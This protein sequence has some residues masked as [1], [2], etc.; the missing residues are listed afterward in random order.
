MRVKCAER[1]GE[2]DVKAV[3][4]GR[5]DSRRGVVFCRSTVGV[6]EFVWSPDVTLK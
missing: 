1:G 6:N 2:G 4:R 5:E 3:A